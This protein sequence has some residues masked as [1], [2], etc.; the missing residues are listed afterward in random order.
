[1]NKSQRRASAIERLRALPP[2]FR[3]SDL[4]LRFGWSTHEAGEYL[5]R[6]KRRDLVKPTG[7]RAG[8]YFNLISQASAAETHLEEA[9]AT[10]FPSAVV[11]GA[12]VLHQAGWI[13]QIP[14][15]L[16][17][18]VL[19]RRTFP[20]VKGVVL[21][22]RSIFW[23]RLVHSRLERTEGQGVPRLDPAFALADALKYR[24]G[25]VPEADDVEFPEAE[26]APRFLRA[27]KTLKVALD[28]DWLNA[29]RLASPDSRRVWE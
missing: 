12:A 14:R 11:V 6:W 25:W 24:D 20:A 5:R 21:H 17:V 13:T 4:S 27:C 9:I 28:H 2:V 7:P 18:A 3:S 1:M 19:R 16:D 26:D 22:P 15:Q 23:Y 29:I 8:V 10:L